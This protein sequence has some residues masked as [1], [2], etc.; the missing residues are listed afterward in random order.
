MKCYDVV[1]IGA[2][3]AGSYAAYKLAEMGYGVAV[4]EQK[5]RLG[6][7]VCCTGIIS[8]R[9]INDFDIDE[10]VVL[11][12]ANSA[13]LVSP[14][15]RLLRLWRQE[16]QA[17]VIDRAVFDVAMAKR[18]QALRILSFPPPPGRLSAF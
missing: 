5:E 7:Q 6:K 15:G 16:T 10:D 12:R 17:G 1:V 13:T 8:Q 18:A 9:C 4:V 3:P 2:G 11:R 14:S